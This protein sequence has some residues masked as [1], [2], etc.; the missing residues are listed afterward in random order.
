LQKG[1]TKRGVTQK[2]QKQVGVNTQLGQSDIAQ[3]TK[4]TQGD[5]GGGHVDDGGD[6]FMGSPATWGGGEKGN[7][8]SM[9]SESPLHGKLAFWGE[10]TRV[11]LGRVTRKGGVW[12][13]ETGPNLTGETAGRR[14]WL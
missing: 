2:W 8:P 9:K 5:K 14:G 7:H 10:V 4:K 1:D 12:L 13:R 3:G 11:P 6:Q